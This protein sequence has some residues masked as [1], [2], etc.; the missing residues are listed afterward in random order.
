MSSQLRKSSLT[1]SQFP[2]ATPSSFNAISC[3]F[4]SNASFG[5]VRSVSRAHRLTPALSECRRRSAEFESQTESGSRSIPEGRWWENRD[6][7]GVRRSS[8]AIV[9]SWWS[10]AL[11]CMRCSHATHLDWSSRTPTRCRSATRPRRLATRSAKP[12]PIVILAAADGAAECP[13]GRRRS[14]CISSACRLRG[15]RPTWDGY[16]P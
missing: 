6:R 7:R 13:P 1:P 12:R 8:A 15:N 4:L 14:A 11:R 10:T 5:P 3:A 2:V 9:A 16:V